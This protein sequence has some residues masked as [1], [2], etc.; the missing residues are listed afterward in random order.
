MKG[1]W[2]WI[3]AMCALCFAMAVIPS[4][5]GQCAVPAGLI[6][7][8][9]WH[10]AVGAAQV[11]RASFRNVDFNNAGGPS[12]V[13]MW[14]VVLTSQTITVGGVL[15]PDS[16][17]V[18]IDNAL[19]VWHSDGTEI[20]NSLRPPQDGNFC[21]GVWKQTGRYQY[22]LNHYAWFANDISTDP[23]KDIG[24]QTGPT[25]IVEQVTLDPNG[26]QFSGGFTMTAYNPDFSVNTVVVG[27][28]SATR[29]TIHTTI[30]DLE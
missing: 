18:P 15:V 22:T 26:N 19:T 4:V 1:N 16:N 28:L 24:P 11:L 20:M 5:W 7:P 13:G 6:K 8:A 23:L 27:T 17:G 3:P 30:S 2:K 14:H 12:I 10:S 9:S 21:M 25:R 29:I